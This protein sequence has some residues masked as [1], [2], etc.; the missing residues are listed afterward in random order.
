MGRSTGPPTV[1]YIDLRPDDTRPVKVLHDDGRW[2]DG[3][4]EAYRKIDGRW[5]GRVRY[6]V[7]IGAQHIGWFTEDRIQRVR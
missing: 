5:S 6:S 3:E 7:A 4:L 1:S 2:Y